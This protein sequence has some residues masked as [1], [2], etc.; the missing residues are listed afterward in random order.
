MFEL[1][2]SAAT[3]D[4]NEHA[5]REPCNSP[6]DM[7]RRDVVVWGGGSGGASAAL[8]S[9]RSGANTTLLTPGPWLGGMVSSAGVCAPDGHELTCWQ[10]GLW[11]AFLRQLEL[12]EPTGLDHNWVSCFGYRPKTAEQILQRWVAAE[13]R[14]EWR[15][16]CRLEHV[17]CQQGRLQ[18]MDIH[19]SNGLET[20]AAEVF[21]D[22]S[23]LGDLLAQ[24]S[25]PCRWGWEA[26]EVWNEPSAPQQSRLESEVFF[27]EQPIQSPTWVVMG[28]LHGEL[29]QHHASAIPRNPF[30]RST[31][32]FGVE[33]TITYGRLP[34]GLVMLN[35]PLEGN[36]WH[37]GLDRAIST[38]AKVRA[39]LAQEM[40]GHSKDFLAALSECSGGWI[41]AGNAF[42]GA[43]PS[44]ALMPYWRE[45]RRLIGRTTVTEHDLL[46]IST[47]ALRGPLPI[48]SEGRCTSIAVGTYANDHHYPGEDWPLAPKSVR[49][50]GRWSG[51]PFCIPFDALISES[52]SNLVMAE[53]G[54]SVSHMANGATRLQP[55]ILNLG[56]VAG[57]AAAMA[58]RQGCGVGDL[59][60]DDIQSAL[61]HEPQAPAAVLPLWDWPHW[62]PHWVEAQEQGLS[63]P[64]QLDA[65]GSLSGRPAS[66]LTHPGVNQAPKQPL[67]IA[68]SGVL[69]GN[70][71]KGY[72]L[73]TAEGVWPLI[74]LEPAIHHWLTASDHAGQRLNL[75][76]IKNPW[77]PWV[78][79]TGVLDQPS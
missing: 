51:T 39:E 31:A 9:A 26:K 42:P 41:A 69:K 22:G 24:T 3:T 18:S 11:G 65:M 17:Q 6:L 19:S 54:F 32:S 10:T 66:N 36:D 70:L 35:W 30:V 27:Q 14:L 23:D 56:Q 40:Q 4:S 8:Q 64:E 77:G 71:Q 45:S 25:S 38:D 28:Q 47:G 78:R 37:I 12:E 21:I 43:D 79:I 55:L 16:H 1:R 53:K 33:R 13:P 58:V 44:L 60:V 15:P 75:R 57:L 46:P 29:A 49:W 67:E 59:A 74:T 72:K 61:I 34:S 5:H 20:F 76:G 68:M 73:Q 48:D 2:C 7:T 52:I 62:H 63:H 50:G